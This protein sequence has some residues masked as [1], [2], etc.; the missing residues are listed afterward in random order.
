[1]DDDRRPDGIDGLPAFGFA[2]P[3]PLRDELTALV[4]AGVKRATAGLIADFIIEGDLIPR[5][6]DRQVVIDSDLRPVAV[7]ETTRCDVTTIG[8]V[9]DEFARA[10]GEGFADREDW[11]RGHERFWN[12]YIDDI[13]RDIGD[14]D[15]HLQ[16]STP[17]VCEW[18]RLIERL[19][20][21][22]TPGTVDQAAASSE[23]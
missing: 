13:R 6:G 20:G 1:M 4:L 23:I 19:D 7:I 18:F 12:G 16:P 21:G 14:P 5:P 3:G 17:V 15:F 8:R 2:F 10:E 11:W 9:T 22:A